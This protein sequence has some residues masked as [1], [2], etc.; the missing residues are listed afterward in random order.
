MFFYYF[1]YFVCFWTLYFSRHFSMTS[2]IIQNLFIQW[3]KSHSSSQRNAQN[4]EFKHQKN[5]IKSSFLKNPNLQ[6]NNS[7]FWIIID[8]TQP[9]FSTKQKVTLDFFQWLIDSS[10]KRINNGGYV[11]LKPL[12]VQLFTIKIILFWALLLLL[13]LLLFLFLDLPFALLIYPFGHVLFFFCFFS[14]LP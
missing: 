13:L 14:N 8:S 7:K 12:S 4:N 2:S 10:S 9:K 11:K 3:T 5:K 1:F 6:M